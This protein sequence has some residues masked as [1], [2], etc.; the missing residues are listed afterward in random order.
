MRKE[1]T[2]FVHKM[3]INFDRIVQDNQFIK[4]SQT[5]GMNRNKNQP[6]LS[7]MK[8]D[9]FHYGKRKHAKLHQKEFLYINIRG[10]LFR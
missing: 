2:K 5:R 4:R 9:D 6:K 7:V 10:K 8:A 1:N 3:Q